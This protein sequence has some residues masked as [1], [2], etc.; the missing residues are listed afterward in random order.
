MGSAELSRGFLLWSTTRE[1]P[2]GDPDCFDTA[3]L[4]GIYDIAAPASGRVTCKLK[5][6]RR[7]QNRNGNLHGGATATLVDV[8]GTAALLTVSPRPG[9]SLA[10]NTN[11]L[12]AMPGDGVVLLDAKVL[13]VGRSVAAI[14]VDLRDEASGRL[15]AQ[16]T[17]VKFISPSEPDLS[18][19]A[20][21]AGPRSKL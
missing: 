7:V 12:E 2:A 13:R 3:A 21:K 4:K 18:A 15:V 10:I 8:V 19:L 17:H 9:V 20:A 16:G 14:T 11:Y 5:V 6:S 1:T